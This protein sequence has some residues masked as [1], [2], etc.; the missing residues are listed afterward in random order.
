MSKA[1]SVPKEEVAIT[2]L[3]C[4]PFI[5]TGVMFNASDLR[6]LKNRPKAVYECCNESARMGIKSFLLELVEKA[7][8][9][10]G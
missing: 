3:T 10:G 7:G 1:R 8:V 4:S 9:H 6:V 2:A 5:K